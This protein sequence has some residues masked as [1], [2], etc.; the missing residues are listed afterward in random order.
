MPD[1]VLTTN[2]LS[3]ED[4]KA[5]SLTD[6]TN[7]SNRAHVV[8]LQ[9]LVTIVLSYQLLFSSSTALDQEEKEFIIL[10]LMILVFLLMVVP[11]RMLE[12]AW[13]TGVLVLGDTVL[14]T[15]VIFV[16]S[17]AVSSLD[18]TYF[19]IIL[20]AASTRTLKQ[21]FAISVILCAAY[22]VVVYVESGESPV[23]LEDHLI[24]IPFLLVM[25][26]FYGVTTDRVRRVS[27][28]KADLIDYI[29]EGK[30]VE[31]ER[32]KLIRQLQDA[33]ASIKTLH[34][35][36]PICANC[37]KIRDDKGYWHSVEAYV[38]DHSEV[39]FTHGICPVCVDKLYG[40]FKQGER[41]G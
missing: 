13:F 20:I 5:P 4:W 30:R 38:S 11:L 17:K 37:K 24:R 27:R 23:V 34:G 2:P 8:L 25:A 18:L 39:D 10:G 16:S 41:G 7:F 15:G 26:V 36:L 29:V 21:M 14:T 40:E 35:L 12:A 6:L 9:T 32:E 22:G 33:L 28:E 31:V 1:T 19:L 3:S